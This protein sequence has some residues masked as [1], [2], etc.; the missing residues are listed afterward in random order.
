MCESFTGPLYDRV[1][2]MVT[3]SLGI[4]LQTLMELDKPSSPLANLLFSGPF[5]AHTQKNRTKARFF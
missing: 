5:L 1:V 4:T 3:A 2:P